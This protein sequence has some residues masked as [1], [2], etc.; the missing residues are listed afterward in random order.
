MGKIDKDEDEECGSIKSHKAKPPD[1]CWQN[2]DL[3]DERGA[4]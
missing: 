2:E 1:H 4:A 3:G